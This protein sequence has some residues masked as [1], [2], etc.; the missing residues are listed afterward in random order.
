MIVCEYQ[1]LAGRFLLDLTVRVDEVCVQLC[2]LDF[3]YKPTSYYV[4]VSP[5][6]LNWVL[7]ES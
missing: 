3:D 6:H 4:E 1:S 7:V 2:D 5:N